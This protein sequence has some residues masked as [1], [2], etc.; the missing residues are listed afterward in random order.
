[1]KPLPGSPDSDSLG[2]IYQLPG[3]PLPED[4][5]KMDADHT[6]FGMKCYIGVVP[7]RG[8]SV[9]RAARIA[10]AAEAQCGTNVKLSVFGDGRTLITIHFRAD[11]AA[12]VARAEP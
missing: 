2:S 11:D 1:M 10:S 4:P 7:L 6:P 8:E 9:R 5:R 3:T 12:Q